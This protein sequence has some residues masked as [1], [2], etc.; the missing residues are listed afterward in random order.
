MDRI[1]DLLKTAWRWLRDRVEAL[2]NRWEKP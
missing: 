1:K 2:M